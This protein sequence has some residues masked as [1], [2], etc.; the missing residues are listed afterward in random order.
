MNSLKFEFVFASREKA[1]AFGTLDCNNAF[2]LPKTMAPLEFKEEPVRNN[3]SVIFLLKGSCSY[4][5]K[6]R[7]SLSL[8]SGS[9]PFLPWKVL[10]LT[11][12]GP[13]L[14]RTPIEILPIS[15]SYGQGSSTGIKR[16]SMIPQP[17][18]KRVK[19]G[20]ILV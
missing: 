10:I 8:I 3:F 9:W 6:V 18:Q 7:G 15:L 16:N 2:K 20:G 12:Q 14:E 17:I 4:L 11:P 1:D 13:G 5:E 19:I